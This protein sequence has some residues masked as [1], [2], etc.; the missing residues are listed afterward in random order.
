MVPVTLLLGIAVLVVVVAR[1][2][3][4]YLALRAFGGHWSSGWSRL[5][6]LQT[7]S[8][9]EMNVRFKKLNDKHGESFHSFGCIARFETSDLSPGFHEAVCFRVD[10]LYSPMHQFS[11]PR[12]MICESLDIITL[13]MF[14]LSASRLWIS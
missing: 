8:S 14:Y 12:H 7:Q 5:W 13:Q 1:S 9:G 2:I 6:L 4:Q 10:K 11:I 3:R